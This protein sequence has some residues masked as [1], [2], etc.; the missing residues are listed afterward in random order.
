M[1]GSETAWGLVMAMWLCGVGL[2]SRIG[3]KVGS[4]ELAHWLPIATLALCGVG[5]LLFR[6]APAI[7][8]TAPGETLTTWHAVWLWALA[9]MPAAAAGGFAFPILAENLGA[10]GPGRAYTLEAAGALFGGLILS[11]ALVPLGTAPAL[12]LVT[13]AVSATLVWPRHRLVAMGIAMVCLAAAGFVGEPL[14]RLSWRWSGHPTELGGWAETR[15]QRLE[16]STGTPTVLYADSRLRASYPEPYTALPRAHLMMLLHPKPARVFAVGCAADGAFEAMVRHPITELV[17][18]EEDPQLISHLAR[19]YGEGFLSSL[20]LPSIRAV[21]TDPL[22]ALDGLNNLDLVILADGDPT[23]LRANRTRTVEF[24]QRCRAAMSETGLLIMSVGVTDTYLG[25]T[26]GRLLATLTSTLREVF[27]KLTALPGEQILLVAGGPGARFATTIQELEERL[28]SRP[29]VSNQLHPAMLSILIDETRQPELEAFIESASAA[30]N[31]LRH[32]IAVGLAARLHEARSPLFR[33]TDGANLESLGSR[34]FVPGLVAWV[35]L[36]LAAAFLG[37]LGVRAIAA[38][39][40][41]GFSSMGWWLLLLAIWQATRGSVYAEVGA[42]TGAFMA[43]VAAGGWLALRSANPVRIL[44][45]ILGGGV[46]LSLLLAGGVPTWAPAL[47]VP[48]F[49]VT[50]GILTGAAFPGLGKLAGRDSVRRGAGVAFS[51]DE[52]GAACAALVIGT[53]AIPWV[54][55]TTT[56]VGLAVLSLAAIPAVLRA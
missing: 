47:M 12:F 55:M 18:V 6:A 25:G 22:R 26:G 16:I 48:T 45:W 51:A 24:F 33:A 23:T 56:A 17:V 10:N 40:V 39:A 41:V 27:P 37:H 43:G 28:L 19:W 31:T 9:V 38:A 30:P 36:L 46:A 13:G 21:T 1:G 11:F 5:T 7:L 2:G 34:L 42:L 53:V 15:H 52:L 54:G 49:L 20:E 4:P 3:V 32:P 29:D 50:G 44:P 8:G 35:A 14:A